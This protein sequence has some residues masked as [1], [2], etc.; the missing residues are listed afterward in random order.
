MDL[1]EEAIQENLLDL[2]ELEHLPGETPE[3]QELQQEQEDRVDDDEAE[4]NEAD[5]HGRMPGQLEQQQPE[6]QQAYQQ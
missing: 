4:E 5:V 1:E 6:A 3:E 2:T